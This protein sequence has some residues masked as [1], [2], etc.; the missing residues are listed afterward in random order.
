MLAALLVAFTGGVGVAAHVGSKVRH[1]DKLGKLGS[2][3]R[4]LGKL[5]NHKKLNKKVKAP[6]D[7]KKQVKAELPEGKK[8]GTTPP[9]R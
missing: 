7:S 3:F 9:R 5:L 8:L 6:V 2:I 1:A 4:R